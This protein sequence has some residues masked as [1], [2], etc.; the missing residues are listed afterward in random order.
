MEECIAV[1]DNLNDISM[2]K[3]A[4]I[5][6]AVENADDSLKALADFISISNNDGAIAQI[7]EKY[8]FA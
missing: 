7:I 1:G 8:G 3:T 2:I 6:V 4:G 5:G